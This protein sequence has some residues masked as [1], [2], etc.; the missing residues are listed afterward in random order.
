M[1][2]RVQWNA[3]KENLTRESRN[4]SASRFFLLEFRFIFVAI[5]VTG[6]ANTAIS[7]NSVLVL[8]T[9]RSRSRR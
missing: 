2:W 4:G 5:K 3:K 1:R 6:H 8:S 9:R 7:R